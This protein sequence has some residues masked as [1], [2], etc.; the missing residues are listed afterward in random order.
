MYWGRNPD[1]G[2]FGCLSCQHIGR[3]VRV[4]AGRFVGRTDNQTG[5]CPILLSKHPLNRPSR[6]ACRPDRRFGRQ[7][8]RSEHIQTNNCSDRFSSPAD[9][10][11]RLAVKVGD[12]NGSSIIIIERHRHLLLFR[13]TTIYIQMLVDNNQSHRL[14]INTSSLENPAGE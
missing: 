8:N 2:R 5:L 13:G 1:R 3:P 14:Y 12:F 9:L 4:S 11:S 7:A 10:I 6:F